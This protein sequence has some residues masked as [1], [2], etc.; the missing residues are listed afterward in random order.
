MH[1]FLREKSTGNKVIKSSLPNKVPLLWR[2]PILWHGRGGVNY[3]GGTSILFG[4]WLQFWF[5]FWKFSGENDA[6]FPSLFKRRMTFSLYEK[7]PK[8]KVFKVCLTGGPCAGKTTTSGAAFGL[9]RSL[10]FT[11]PKMM[12][13]IL[14]CLILGRDGKQL[15]CTNWNLLILRSFEN[16]GLV[17]LLFKSQP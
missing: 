13:L 15:G 11:T 5:V 16:F 9:P 6:R 14:C 10:N 2:G 4:Y 3:L 17:W 8:S 12:G 7:Q 1:P